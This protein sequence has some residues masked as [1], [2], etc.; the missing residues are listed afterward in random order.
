MGRVGC[1]CRITDLVVD[2]YR[3]RLAAVA[4]EGG[5]A[6]WFPFGRGVRRGCMLCPPVFS[7]CTE[8]VMLG[9]NADGE[10]ASFG[11][12][13]VRGR[14]VGEL[15]YADDT[16]LFAQGPE[17]LRGLLQSVRTHG[18]GGGLCLN[19]ERTRIMGLDRGLTT[20]VDV[21]GERLEGVGG[22]VCLGSGIDA[23]GKSGPDVRRR[24]AIAVSKL[25]TV[26]PL[27]GSRSAELGWRTLE[28]CIF[29]VAVCGCEA[30][31]ISGAD[32]RGITSFEMGC[33]R[34]MLGVSWTERE[35]GAGVLERLGVRAPRL[36]NLVGRQRLSC[37]GRIGQHS[38]L[39]KL[40]LGGTCEGMRGR[41]RPRRRWTQD[42]GEWMG[43]S[44]V[45]AGRQTLQRGEFRQAVWEATSIKD[46]P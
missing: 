8:T 31:A 3:E 35:A 30:W 5:L 18:E 27:W 10:L 43:V 21:D 40:F 15:K 45:E 29:P 6:D 44:T 7:M 42:I 24:I 41:G 16:V 19:A 23:G 37:F 22:F 11:A 4:L 14:E 12:V 28:A 46:P 32:G 39:G 9:L 17:G 38:A 1:H 25:S 13:G 2:L 36:L 26:A 34:G 33:C 20:T